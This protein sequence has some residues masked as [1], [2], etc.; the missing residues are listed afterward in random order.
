M[1]KRFLIITLI[2]I[3][4]I[5]LTLT[6]KS[7]N[8]KI[9]GEKS[10]S[11]VGDK[12]AI[13]IEEDNGEFTPT[14]RDMFPTLGEGYILDHSDCIDRHRKTLESPVIDIDPYNI[15][16][17]YTTN[18]LYCNLY[19]KK[20]SWE[21]TEVKFKFENS[22]Q[23]VHER[24]QKYRIE[25]TIEGATEYCITDGS[26]CDW[27]TIPYEMGKKF[28]EDNIEIQGDSGQKTYYVK[29]KTLFTEQESNRDGLY[30]QLDITPPTCSLKVENNKIVFARI[31]DDRSAEANIVRGISRT[32]TTTYGNINSINVSGTGEYYGY[33]K[34][35]AGNEGRC[36]IDVQNDY[37]VACSVTQTNSYPIYCNVTKENPHPVYCSVT[38][39][40]SEP[41]YCNVTSANPHPVFCAV[42]GNKP[43]SK[44]CEVKSTNPHTVYCNVTQTNSESVNCKVNKTLMT[45]IKCSVTDTKSETKNCTV[46]QKLADKNT[47]CYVTNTYD[48][49]QY[50]T[51]T[52]STPISGYTYIGIRCN[53]GYYP[54]QDSMQVAFNGVST[55]SP[56]NWQSPFNP[57]NYYHSEYEINCSTV[58][59]LARDPS[60]YRFPYTSGYMDGNYEFFLNSVSYPPAV[61]A[62][63]YSVPQGVVYTCSNGNICNYAGCCSNQVCGNV[64]YDYVCS[65]GITYSNDSS[66]CTNS[67]CS[68][69]EQY[70]CS[71]GNIYE[72]RNECTSK[73][74]G[75]KDSYVCS[76]GSTYDTKSTC[77]N[78]QC[79]TNY[80]YLC[81]DGETYST[82]S[83]CTNKQCD[84]KNT[85][86]CSNGKQYS[87]SDECTSRQCGTDY[88]Y[89]CS[90]GKEYNTSDEC[91]SKTCNVE[92]QYSCSNGKEY[93]SLTTCTNQ[94][95]DTRYTYSC[96]DGEEYNS[97]SSCTN[98]VCDTKYTYSCSNGEE[99]NSSSTCTSTQCDTRYTY[100]CSNGSEYDSQSTC[101]NTQCSTG[102]TYTCSDGS[103]YDNQNSCISKECGRACPTGYTKDGG[104][105]YKEV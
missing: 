2:I 69:K 92:Y 88:T 37:G 23:T 52:K 14:N 70:K 45:P 77:E 13:Y 3:G 27:K 101:T 49:T 21:G 9:V 1:K 41:V 91:T 79:G 40:N 93:P 85:Y 105:C 63:C 5:S 61:V 56:N 15:A 36:T 65:N 35:E 39:E 11:I 26:S 102:Y 87:T 8:N 76:D 73:S 74:C 83:D 89:S 38:K 71:D 48:R 58:C 57:F 54:Y 28:L 43:I 46:T 7:Y 19:F 99:Y 103:T 86:S 95:C 10:P 67:I 51:Q 78:K 75:T 94:Q 29:L 84:T 42:T 97:Q 100:S 53:C 80:S 18:A 31:H 64:S 33:V 98:S 50:C 60:R 16:H 6:Y 62:F 59:S 4:I 82:S 44:Y 90:D 72:T 24:N 81:S 68:S 32:N 96:S 55:C 25:W 20:Y 12:F 34:D 17:V 47:Y 66:A 30:L 104:Y 22:G